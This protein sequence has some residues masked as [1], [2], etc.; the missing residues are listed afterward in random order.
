MEM[1]NIE[2]LR[3]SRMARRHLFYGV[4]FASPWLLGM[5]FFIAYPVVASLYY[6]FTEYSVL[7]PVKGFVGLSNYTALIFGDDEFRRSLYNSVYYALFSIPLGILTSVSIALMLEMED[8]EAVKTI[9]NG[10]DSVYR[11]EIKWNYD[12]ETNTNTCEYIK[13]EGKTEVTTIY[14]DLSAGDKTKIDNLKTF[15]E[16][17]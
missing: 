16:T 12:L 15:L 8:I 2:A 14:N 5:I 9:T 3:T 13:C 1:F 17:R 7:T 6:S 10:V 4:L 11:Q